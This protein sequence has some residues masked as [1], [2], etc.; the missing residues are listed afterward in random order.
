MEDELFSI[1]V[2]YTHILV[3]THGSTSIKIF[4]IPPL[5]TFPT[6]ED[7]KVDVPSASLIWEWHTQY[8]PTRTFEPTILMPH[9]PCVL[10]L[11]GETSSRNFHLVAEDTLTL[12]LIE[13]TVSLATEPGAK[14]DTA[15]RHRVHAAAREDVA[16]NT[17]LA[18]RSHRGAWLTKGDHDLTFST[19]T[20]QDYSVDYLKGRDRNYP[21]PL[22]SF[23][24]ECPLFDP[25]LVDWDYDEVSG[26]FCLLVQG[27]DGDW[28]VLL[29]DRFE[30]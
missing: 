10:V 1:C 5:Q 23:G 19:L 28:T 24:V 6:S 30:T 12:H 22:G 29:V 27:D 20:F 8:I 9:T 3:V 18:L 14:V 7:K 26:R 17:Y 15:I 21:L 25:H 13:F 11:P 16:G 2:P 4:N